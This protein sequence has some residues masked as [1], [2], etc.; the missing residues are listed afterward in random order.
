MSYVKYFEDSKPELLEQ[1]INDYVS[2]NEYPDIINCQ[3]GV[4]QKPVN[5]K[6]LP[7]SGHPPGMIPVEMY[8]FAWVTFKSSL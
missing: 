5:S 1:S 8:Y 6:L 4:I 7:G 3:Y 2:E